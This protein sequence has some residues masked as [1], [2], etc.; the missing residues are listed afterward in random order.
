MTDQDFHNKMNYFAITRAAEDYATEWS[1]YEVDNVDDKM[2]SDKVRRVFYRFY[3]KD[4]TMEQL[5]NDT[6]QII[7]V[8]SFANDGSVRE[9][10]RAAESCYQQAKALGDF[11]YF[12]EDFEM[13]DDGS[14]EMAMGS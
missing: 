13:H 9:L 2:L 4:A 10:W 1:I 3:A 6:A 7:E 8:S 14:L 12:I 11:H 5:M